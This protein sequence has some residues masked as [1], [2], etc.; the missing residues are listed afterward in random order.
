[1]RRALFWFYLLAFYALCQLIGWG[2][3]FVKYVPDRKGM[4]IGEGLIF[5]AIFILAVIK[6]KN[7]LGRERYYR[8]QQQNFLLAVTH[9]L[10]SPLASVKLYLQTI[11]KR[12]LDR[13]QQM[14][15]LSNSLKD[16]ERLDYLVENVLLATKLENRSFNL[17]K[18]DFN[19]SDL[20]GDILD[21]LQKNACKTEVINPQ[22]EENLILYADKFA[23][24]NVV[25]N[26][27]ENA[28]KYSPPCAHVDV[29]L[30]KR[31]D[32]VVFSVSDHGVGI[33]D[34][35]KKLIFNKFYRIG[36][37]STRKTKGTGLGLYIVKSVLH[38]HNASIVVK[39]N[40][41]S[42]SVFEVTFENYAN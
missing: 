15:F 11:L 14:M 13:E 42:G 34:E 5:L 7:H 37:E 35:E 1:M 4:V 16:I 3:M 29:A 18:E 21:R 24:T 28:I 39:D 17:P 22:I 20:V 23:I 36:N 41:P 40:K 10:K 32:A 9:E 38:K 26:L 8:Q 27:V 19:L 12:D 25:T 31:D 33:P 2:Y 30:Y 6:L